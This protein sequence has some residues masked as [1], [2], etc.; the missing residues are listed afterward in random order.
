MPMLAGKLMCQKIGLRIEKTTKGIPWKGCTC[1]TSSKNLQFHKIVEFD[2][3]LFHY[4]RET[5]LLQLVVIYVAE[6]L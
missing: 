1:C 2:L 6:N 3:I 4:L 5:K